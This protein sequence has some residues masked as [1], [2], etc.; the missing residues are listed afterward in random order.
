MSEPPAPDDD[1][2]AQSADS[3]VSLGEAA[4][5]LG[6]SQQTLRRWADRG[7]VKSFVTPG[8]HRRF[9]R[10][11]LTELLPAPRLRRPQLADLGSSLDRM[12]DAYRRRLDA[13]GSP[14]PILALL[15]ESERERFRERGRRMVELLLNHLDADSPA[16]ALASLH[17]AAAHAV[18]YG[19]IAAGLGASLGEGI[20]MFLR[21]RAPFLEELAVIARRRRLDT[22]EA[23][24]LLIDAEAAFDK[25]LLSFM[26]GW[27]EA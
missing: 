2:D 10:S 15:P 20:E 26:A 5:Q 14:L 1:L 17:E 18:E 3:W 23:T 9:Q 21:Y 13:E 4:R 19:V 24:G 12:A 6:I 16:V 25:L 7:Q 27:Q 22:A 11:V 8:G